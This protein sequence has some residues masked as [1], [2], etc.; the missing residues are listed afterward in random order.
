[1]SREGASSGLGL[2][3]GIG[4]GASGLIAAPVAGLLVQH[5]GFTAHYIFMAAICMLALIPICMIRET[6]TMSGEG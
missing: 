6:A 1:M 5:F 3:I 4:L 2:M